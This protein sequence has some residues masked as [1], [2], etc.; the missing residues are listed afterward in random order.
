M[1]SFDFEGGFVPDLAVLASG[2]FVRRFF[3]RT[4]RVQMAAALQSGH[5]GQLQWQLESREDE[6]Y[7]AN[8][9]MRLRNTKWSP[10]T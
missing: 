7:V 9:N 6:N 10:G 8:G 4:Y 2:W 3:R 1:A 5:P